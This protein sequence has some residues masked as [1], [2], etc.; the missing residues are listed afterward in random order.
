MEA[1]TKINEL[2]ALVKKQQIEIETVTQEK[3]I[4]ELH[5]DMLVSQVNVSS[6]IHLSLSITLLKK[7]IISFN[8][9]IFQYI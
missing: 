4:I 6:S 7:I 3:Q 9:F 8:S 2:E 1:T 5:R